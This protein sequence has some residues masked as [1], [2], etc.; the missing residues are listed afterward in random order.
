MFWVK[1]NAFYGS[2]FI[3]QKRFSKNEKFNFPENI[4]DT[5]IISRNKIV[6]SKEIYKFTNDYFFME[7]IPLIY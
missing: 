7:I 4:R 5:I 1:K 2:G 6:Y 3:Y